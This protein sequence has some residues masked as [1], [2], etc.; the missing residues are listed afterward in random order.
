MKGNGSV[1]SPNHKHIKQTMLSEADAY[2]RRLSLLKPNRIIDRLL[3]RKTRTSQQKTAPSE[4][5]KVWQHYN[6]FA[7]HR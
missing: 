4:I 1:L 6:N 2:M 7:G 5:L 3:E